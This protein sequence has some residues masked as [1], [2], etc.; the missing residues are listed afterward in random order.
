MVDSLGPRG[1]G[2]TTRNLVDA[3]H[4]FKSGLTGQSAR[5]LTDAYIEATKRPWTQPIGYQ[6]ALFE[7]AI[8]VLKRAK[9]IEPEGRS[10]MPSSRPTITRS[11][12]R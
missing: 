4:P 2:L 9:S 11:S 5:Q 6:H 1:N 7:V 3:D 8:D 10:S 12:G